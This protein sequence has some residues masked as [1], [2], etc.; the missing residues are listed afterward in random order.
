MAVA[1][2]PLGASLGPGLSPAFPLV[3]ARYAEKPRIT[4]FPP[5][6]QE[7]QPCPKDSVLGLFR[8]HADTHP[9]RPALVDRERSFSYRELDRLSDRLAAHLARRG[10]AQA[11]CCPCWPRRSAELVIAI[12]AA[13]KCAA[14]YV[15]VDRRQPD[16]RKAGNPP[17]VPGPLGPRHPG[18][19]PAGAT[20]GGHRTGARDEC[21][22]CRAETGA[23]RR[24]KRCM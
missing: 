6:R 15:P 19:G 21:G 7:S 9:E 2:F 24:L 20:G 13:A 18:R 3:P 5:A 14:A 10:V 12:L 4:S 23:R 1:A 8:Q 22:G 11:S 16:R 17:P